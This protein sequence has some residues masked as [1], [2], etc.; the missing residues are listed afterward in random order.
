MRCG[1]LDSQ[2]WNARELW[3]NV[4]FTPSDED[5]FIIKAY[6]YSASLIVNGSTAARRQSSP[7]IRT[8]S[9]CGETWNRENGSEG[10]VE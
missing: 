2:F 1:V 5:Q 8:L 3:Q 6:V 7:A 10:N 4:Q 9:L